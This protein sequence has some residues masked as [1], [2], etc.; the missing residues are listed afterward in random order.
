MIDGH[1][2]RLFQEVEM[3]VRTDLA[4]VQLETTHQLH[5]RRGGVR[6]GAVSGKGSHPDSSEQLLNGLPH[7]VKGIINLS[8]EHIYYFIGGRENRC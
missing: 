3:E 8:Q 1:G 2:K 4:M 5:R 7:C 6:S